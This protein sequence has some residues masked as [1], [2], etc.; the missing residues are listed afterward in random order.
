M[1]RNGMMVRNKSSLIHSRNGGLSKNSFL[2]LK[3]S[4]FIPRLGNYLAIIRKHNFV[5]EALSLETG[6]EVQKTL[7]LCV[8]C[9][10]INT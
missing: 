1:V 3:F 8:S 10:C 7:V 5:G 2:D 9:L 4:N 6:S